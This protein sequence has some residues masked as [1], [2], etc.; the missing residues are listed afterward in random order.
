M[1]RRQWAAARKAKTCIRVRRFLRV[2]SMTPPWS[3][4]G[5]RNEPAVQSRF[6]LIYKRLHA[7]LDD[8]PP[9]LPVF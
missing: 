8:L 6:L 1:R 7:S 2:P 3:K 5:A 9:P 4:E